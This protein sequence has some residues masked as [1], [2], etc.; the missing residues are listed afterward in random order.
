MKKPIAL[1]LSAF[2]AVIA[3]LVVIQITRPHS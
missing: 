2:I 1:A 3:L